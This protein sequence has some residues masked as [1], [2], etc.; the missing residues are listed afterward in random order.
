MRIFNKI[1]QKDPPHPP[2]TKTKK[3]KTKHFCLTRS[4]W[5]NFNPW[6]VTLDCGLFCHV[7]SD[8]KGLA[9]YVIQ[10]FLSSKRQKVVI[11]ELDTCEVD[12]VMYLSVFLI[13]TWDSETSPSS[14]KQSNKH[15]HLRPHSLSLSASFSILLS[16]KKPTAF[17]FFFW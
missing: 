3:Q 13:N 16:K 14:R 15:H 7:S 9:K 8:K 10:I 5:Y 17:F 4:V 1:E 11:G 6:S 12:L 2:K